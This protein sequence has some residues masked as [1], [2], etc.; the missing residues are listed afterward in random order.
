MDPQAR[1]RLNLLLLRNVLNSVPSLTESDDDHSESSVL[2]TE[3]PAQDNEEEEDETFLTA[4]SKEGYEIVMIESDETHYKSA[5]SWDDEQLHC[6]IYDTAMVSQSS[7]SEGY[8]AGEDTTA[9]T[10]IHDEEYLPYCSSRLGEE[11]LP[12]RILE[13]GD[14]SSRSFAIEG[15]QV[16][17]FIRDL[18]REAETLEAT[19]LRT[20]A[21]TGSTSSNNFH[22]TAKDTNHLFGGP[23]H[24]M[25]RARRWEAF[26]DPYDVFAEVFDG[27]ELPRRTPAKRYIPEETTSTSTLQHVNANLTIRTF[28]NGKKVIRRRERVD[29]KWVMTVETI[30]P[31]EVTSNDDGDD[32]WLWCCCA[33]SY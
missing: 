4:N 30:E 24:I 13:C 22:Y 10:S 12:L 31:T 2:E 6:R 27:R 33:I 8:A 7:S 32:L 28:A 16:G 1:R 9:V 26:S 19:T 25:H 3:S 14:P 18:V 23:L 17:P 29:G 11:I 20:S 21:S 15:D 5:A